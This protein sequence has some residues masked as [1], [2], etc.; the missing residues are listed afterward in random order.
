[1]EIMLSND[2]QG[3]EQ[4]SEA[5]HTFAKENGLDSATAYKLAVCLDELATN[6]IAHGGAR[7]PEDRTRITAHVDGQILR[8]SIEDAGM[9]FNPLT[10]PDPEL[11]GD[12]DARPVGRLG[13]FLVKQMMDG[14]EYER[15]GNWNIVRMF[16]NL[17]AQEGRKS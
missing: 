11:T 15:R 17:K 2:L 10:R 5:L 1:M 7:S 14:V 13:I 12:V 6:V 8:A 3:L 9:A 16:K 4:L